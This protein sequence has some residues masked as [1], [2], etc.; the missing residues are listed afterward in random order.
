MNEMCSIATSPVVW[1]K[2]ET[3][4]FLELF[5]KMLIL[6][7]NLSERYRV[8]LSLQEAKLAHLAIQYTFGGKDDRVSSELI[9][10]T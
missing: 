4:S 1:A 6:Q 5:V 10:C 8:F 9:E 7:N 3:T 2:K